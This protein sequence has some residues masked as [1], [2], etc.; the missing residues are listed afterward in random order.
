MALACRAGGIAETVACADAHEAAK[1]LD[2][3]LSRKD[4]GVVLVLD[5]YLTAIPLPQTAGAYPVVIGMPGRSGP[6]HGED[7]AGRAARR[8]AGRSL[9]GANG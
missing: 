9:P 1:A 2:S 7:A 8:V 6:A 4:I 5:R 3:I